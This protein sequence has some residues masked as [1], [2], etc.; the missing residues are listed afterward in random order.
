MEKYISQAAVNP[1][2]DTEI[3]D[4]QWMSIIMVW[5]QTDLGMVGKN[6]SIHDKNI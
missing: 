4:S 1:I 3:E 5:H 2:T 6:H